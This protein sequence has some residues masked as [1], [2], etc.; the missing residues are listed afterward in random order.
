MDRDMDL[1]QI[2][3]KPGRQRGKG[4]CSPLVKEPCA[5]LGDENGSAVPKGLAAL[6]DTTAFTTP[7]Y[8]EG[9]VQILLTTTYLPY[10][11]L[12]SYRF[13]ELSMP[14]SIYR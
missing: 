11:F 3:L 2:E 4:P 6:P 10:R 13:E 9:T 5:S 12:G 1:C 14:A 8:T 7:S